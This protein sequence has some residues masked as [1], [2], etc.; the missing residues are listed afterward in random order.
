MIDLTATLRKK[1]FTKY[2][3]TC[4]KCGFIDE[5]CEDIVV[6]VVARD[7]RDRLYTEDLLSVLCKICDKFAPAE[8]KYFNTYISEKIDSNVLETFRKAGRGT[9][10]RVK[11][12]MQEAHAEGKYIGRAPFGYILV[13]GKLT[14]DEE[15]MKIVKAIFLDAKNG[16]GLREIGRK[17]GLSAP[18]V[19]KMLENKIYQL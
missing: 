6:H 17:Y 7:F 1:I 2:G 9:S 18:G 15:K 13:N 19:K 11:K 8:E 10:K 4:Q 5:N 14:I 3:Y 16:L 12:G